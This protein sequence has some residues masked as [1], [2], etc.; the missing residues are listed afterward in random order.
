MAGML[1]KKG[2][3]TG[4]NKLLGRRNWKQRFFVLSLAHSVAQLQ[5]STVGHTTGAAVLLH[6]FAPEVMSVSATTRAAIA[7]PAVA[8]AS[9]MQG[10]TPAEPPIVTAV[11]CD[12]P[13]PGDI[14]TQDVARARAR[15]LLADVAAATT[16][17]TSPIGLLGTI[18]LAQGRSHAHRADVRSL[19][20]TQTKHPHHFQI[21]LST[22]LGGRCWD[23]RAASDDE[24]E[25][26][27]TA[28]HGAAEYA[29]DL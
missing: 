17:N 15:R 6:Y 10:G 28:I 9:S 24:R 1:L 20:R 19:D 14:D 22:N 29:M 3:G 26:W 5:T 21:A 23:L 13:S 27:I 4:S 16:A 12:P 18:T 25:T 7:A 11:P 8:N 2:G